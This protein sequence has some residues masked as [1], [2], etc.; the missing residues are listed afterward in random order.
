MFLSTEMGS[1]PTNSLEQKAISTLPK[2]D[3]LR[4]LRSLT[5]YTV[6][7][8]D[9]CF[10]IIGQIVG[11][12]YQAARYQPTAIVYINSPVESRVLAQAVRDVWSATNAPQ[13]LLD[14]LLFDY[15][16]EGVFNGQ[17]L[18]GWGIASELQTSA[19]LRM[20]Y[21][22][23]DE[24]A[25]MIADRL[26][27]LDVRKVHDVTNQIAREVANGVRVEGFI[28]SV[29]Q[30]S[31]PA[32]QRELF[33]IFNRTGDPELL[34]AVLPGIRSEEGD[35]VFKRLKQVIDELPADEHGPYGIGYNSLV[36]LGNRFGDAARPVFQ[37]YLRNA[38]LQRWR[39][40]A[41]V[42]RKTRAQWAAELLRPALT[43]KRE[44]G[45]SYPVVPGH[46][47]P[48]RPIR[49]CDEA[50]ETIS[51]SRTNFHFQMAGEHENLDRQIATMQ[52]DI[53]RRQR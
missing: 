31:A 4:D 47:E 41:M 19:A 23:P 3:R 16:T 34:L 24:T 14:S 44:F 33:N 39:S 11:R 22:F 46:N 20:L 45:W 7:V 50:A 9:V 15:A 48:R 36:A 21:Y 10:T 32:V 35:L 49:V 26:A 18:D 12:R 29:T 53:E 40:M 2:N 38:S 17:S 6:K 30:S 13:H 28:K 42:L 27:R 25:E 8:G 52:R 51:L 43:D 1:N 37:D 5:Q